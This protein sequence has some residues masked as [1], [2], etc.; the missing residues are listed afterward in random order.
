MDGA[1]RHRSKS[2]VSRPPDSVE[3][4]GARESA[5]DQQLEA[6]CDEQGLLR[7]D[8]PQVELLLAMPP[9]R[10]PECCDTGCHPCVKD[11]QRVAKLLLRLRG[12]PRR[13]D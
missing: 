6:V 9:E 12:A 10:W 3:S 13:S 8:Y 2:A 5:L 1:H 11:H 4:A 7:S